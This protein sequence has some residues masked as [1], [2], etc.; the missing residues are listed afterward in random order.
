MREDEH[1]K[2]S[3]VPP[4]ARKWLHEKNSDDLREIDDA[5]RLTMKIVVVANVLKWLCL[6]VAGAIGIG[7]G[8][9]SIVASGW[10]HVGK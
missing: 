4:V 8:F 9:A 2:W 1:L 6:F 3:E 10:F 7:G 5:A